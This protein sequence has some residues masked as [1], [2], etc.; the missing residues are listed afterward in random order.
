[1]KKVLSIVIMLLVVMTAGA[2]EWEKKTTEADPMLGTKADVIYEWQNAD[3]VFSFSEN[4]NSW[5]VKGW[6]FKPDATHLNHRQNFE[7]YAK[8]G[9]YNESDELVSMF[10]KCKLELTDFYNRATSDANKKNKG[11]YAVTEYLKNEKGYVRIIIPTMQGAGFDVS[12]PC[13]NN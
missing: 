12:I 1:M 2:Q 9:F 13:L 8:I 3:C 11:Q 10:D 7:T 4:S 5:S 6:A